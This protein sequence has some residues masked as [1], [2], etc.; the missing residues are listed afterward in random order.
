MPTPI[1]RGHAW[2]LLL[3]PLSAGVAGRPEAGP[4]DDRAVADLAAAQRAQ[5]R[6]GQVRRPLLE[7]RSEPSPTRRNRR[8]SGSN[9][10]QDT[11]HSRACYLPADAFGPG[12]HR[13]R[14]GRSLPVRLQA[15]PSQCIWPGT[16]AVEPWTY[17]PVVHA[18]VGVATTAVALE[19]SAEQDQPV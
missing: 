15:V 7:V 16:P 13:R 18:V 4:H 5:R 9:G 8:K 6:P 12:H 11:V 14:R 3:P 1:Q 19:A 10:T 17:W 2:R